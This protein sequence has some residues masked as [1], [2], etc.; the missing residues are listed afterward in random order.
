MIIEL[1][2]VAITALLNGIF[3]IISI[4][5]ID[6]LSDF[7]SN[8]IDFLFE[9]INQS[10]GLIFLFIRPTTFV[11]A[12]TTA[13]VIINLDNIWKFVL[14]VLKKIPFINIK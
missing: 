1:L 4:P 7:I 6:G 11:I 9:L 2:M 5:N 10:L 3:S 12:L 13:I 14:W 8:S